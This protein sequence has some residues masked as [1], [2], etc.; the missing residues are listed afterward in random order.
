MEENQNY[1]IAE[2]FT[3]PSKGLIYETKINPVIKLRSMTA[4]DEM[5]RLAPSATPLKTLA[6][7]IE[8]CIVSEKL[9]IKVYDLAN[10]DY[11]F[12]LH[13]LRTVTYGPDYKVYLKCPECGENVETIFKLDNL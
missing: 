2:E 3:L 1:T 8:G 11:E 6:E 9:P 13:K 5:K 10:S 12:L 7:I 4:R